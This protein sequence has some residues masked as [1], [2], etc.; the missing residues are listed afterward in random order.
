MTTIAI[1]FGTSNTVVSLLEPDTQLPKTLRF[2]G[3][4]RLFQQADDEVPIIPTLVFVK[5]ANHLLLGEQVRSQRLGLTQPDRLFKAFK[6]D[7]AAD[8]QPPARQLDGVSY[9]VE[10]VAEQF[11]LAIWQ[12]LAQLQ[13]Q[14]SQVIFTVPVGA[15]ERYLTWFRDMAAKLGVAAIQVVDESTAAALGY[16][17]ER[18]KSLV[19]V[20]DFGGGTLDLSLVR[21]AQPPGKT[22]DTTHILQAE[23]LAKTDAY[24]G[25]EDIDIWIV[26]NYLQ[27]SGISR[28]TVGKIGWQNLL[29]LAERLKIQLSSVE[30]AKESWLDE[31]SFM[32]HELHLSRTQFEEILETRQLLEQLRQALDEVLAIA[33]GKGIPKSQIEQVLLVGG[34]CFIPAVQQ[35]IVSY[36]GRQRVRLNKPFEA[37]A[38]GALLLNRSIRVEDYL[39]HSYAI[40]LWQPHTQTYTYFPLFQQGTK[41]PCQRAEPLILQVANAGQTELRLDIGEVAAMTQAE[42]TYDAQGRMTSTALHQQEAYRSL[43]SHHDKVCVA[44]LNPPGELG[45]DRVSVEFEVTE[46]RLLIA[47]VR[48][49]LTA[50]LLVERGVVAKLR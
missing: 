6:R 41:Y 18:P 31:T 44:H 23:V 30:T 25:G 3:I 45:V 20:V 12:Q 17:V 33:L 32:A 1:D 35:L 48:D 2:P 7:L 4:S 5:E 28:E 21:T 38:H 50:Q 40:R 47:T 14:P 49:L 36:F 34:S 19:L 27:Q 11:L 22:T 16:A 9:P 39:R 42:V 26:E 15:F 46:Q 29:E 43:E 8:V 10:L 24:L 37:V 13:I